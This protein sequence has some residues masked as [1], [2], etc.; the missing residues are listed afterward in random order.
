MTDYQRQLEDAQEQLEKLAAE[1]SF[2]R[3]TRINLEEELNQLRKKLRKE[4]DDHRQVR[5]LIWRHVLEQE[6]KWKGEDLS[7]PIN[8]NL[9][10]VQDE[11][12]FK[13]HLQRLEE[14]LKSLQEKGENLVSL[15][16]LAVIFF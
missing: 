3:R 5:R 12:M 15:L 4:E 7:V 8:K 2:E 14:K 1:L 9:V 10:L 16:C 6:V 13:E 11:S